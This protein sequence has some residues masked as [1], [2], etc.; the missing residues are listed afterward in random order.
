MLNIIHRE[1]KDHGLH[2]LTLYESRPAITFR[3]SIEQY[4]AEKSNIDMLEFRKNQA[5][6][7]IRHGLLKELDF[8][9]HDDIIGLIA[10]L[11]MQHDNKPMDVRLKNDVIKMLKHLMEIY[12]T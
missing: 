2:N 3:W 1:I 5:E 10:A 8:P 6:R 4:E 11:N 12:R 9:D 7:N